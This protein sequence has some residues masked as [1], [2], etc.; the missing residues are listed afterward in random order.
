MDLNLKS[1]EEFRNPSH[2]RFESVLDDLR[3]ILSH[4]DT[5]Q[6]RR[7]TIAQIF[8]EIALMRHEIELEGLEKLVDETL[9]K[10]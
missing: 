5:D 3:Y 6:R 1:V 7:M 9:N 10:P 4:N 2:K 8:L